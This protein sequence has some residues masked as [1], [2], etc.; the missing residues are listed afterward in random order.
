[1][2]DCKK[3]FIG[4]NRAG[5]VSMTAGGDTGEMGRTGIPTMAYASNVFFGHPQDFG[6]VAGTSSKGTRCSRR[7]RENA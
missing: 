4:Q 3:S 1:M 5:D 6:R 2:V 7:T